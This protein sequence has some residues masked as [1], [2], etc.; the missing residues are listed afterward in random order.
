MIDFPFARHAGRRYD[1]VMSD[2][3][4]APKSTRSRGPRNERSAGRVVFRPGPTPA[5]PRQYLLLDYGKHWD[6]P[7]GHVEPAE[8]DRTAALREMVEETGISDVRVLPGFAREMT[9]F[10]R[11]RKKRLVRKT[12]IFFLASTGATD[13][14]VVLSDEHVGFAFLNY[15]D[16]LRRLTY[17]AARDMLQHADA[18]LRTL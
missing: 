6:Y 10:F 18:Y 17:P 13:E 3:T 16:A 4:P 11:D 2:P 12:V 14:Q 7:K 15:D 8:D 9:Y 5:D 1:N